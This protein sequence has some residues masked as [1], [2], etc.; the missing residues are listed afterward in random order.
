VRRLLIQRPAIVEAPLKKL[1]PFG[2]YRN[3]IGF[4]RQKAPKRRM[5]PAQLMK[6]AVSVLPYSFAKLLDLSDELL[7]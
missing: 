4:L 2:H 3:G 7:A 6:R 5:V 1:R